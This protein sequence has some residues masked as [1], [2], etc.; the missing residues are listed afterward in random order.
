M[1]GYFSLSVSFIFLVYD[2]F[3]LIIYFTKTGTRND[4]TQRTQSIRNGVSVLEMELLMKA[5]LC[6]AHDNYTFDARRAGSPNARAR[7][8]CA[9]RTFRDL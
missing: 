8:V 2:L 7:P 6:S 9:R 5:S 1:Q 3:S 4:G